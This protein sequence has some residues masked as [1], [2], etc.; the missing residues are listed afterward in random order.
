MLVMVLMFRP[1]DIKYS[2]LFFFAQVRSRRNVLPVSEPVW[3]PVA[4]IKGNQ[5]LPRCSPLGMAEL[6]ALQL[7]HLVS[8]RD[9]VRNGLVPD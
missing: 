6:I 2:I 9:E 8:G 5:P 7:C 4:V 1:G 3:L